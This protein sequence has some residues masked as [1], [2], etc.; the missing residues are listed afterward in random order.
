MINPRIYVWYNQKYFNQQI[1]MHVVS[2]QATSTHAT[3]LAFGV[4]VLQLREK[5]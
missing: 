3:R 2:A 5:G 1:G 4:L